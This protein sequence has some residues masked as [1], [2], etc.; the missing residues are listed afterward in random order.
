MHQMLWWVFFHRVWILN[1]YTLY[2]LQTW[3]ILKCRGYCVLLLSIRILFNCIGDDVVYSVF[4][5]VLF[6]RSW[7]DWRRY[8]CKMCQR[9]F[10]TGRGISVH[11]V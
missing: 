10:F 11:W 9:I 1:R 4:S 6:N 5:W 7:S 2:D 8:V 3:F